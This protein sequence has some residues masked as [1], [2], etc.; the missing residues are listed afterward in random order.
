ML[1]SFFS[2]CGL[3]PFLREKLS[4]STKTV[5]PAVEPRFGKRAEAKTVHNEARL[6][7]NSQDTDTL[8]ASNAN[9]TT[10]ISKAH[11]KCCFLSLCGLKPS[12]CEKL[13][14]STKTVIPAGE[15]QFGKRAEAKTVRNEERL[16][17]K[18]KDTNTLQANNANRTCSTSKAHGKWCFLSFLF[19]SIESLVWKTVQL[20]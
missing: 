1:F 11:G 14:S 6:V 3:K 17:S 19:L 16:L 12:S 20:N 9:Q 2:L 10:S 15:P 13:S 5:I 8:Q 7:S 4:S 18:G